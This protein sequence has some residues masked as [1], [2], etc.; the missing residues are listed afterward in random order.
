[1]RPTLSPTARATVALTMKPSKAPTRS[2]T[3]LPSTRPTDVPSGLPST[4]PSE[5]PTTPPSKD[6][7]R[8]PSLS[9]SRLP[10]SVPTGLP[11][12]TPT[13]RPSFEQYVPEEEATPNSSEGV[14]TFAAFGVAGACVGGAGCCGAFFWCSKEKKKASPDGNNAGDSSASAFGTTAPKT[15][16]RPT[17]AI[18]VGS[19]D[20]AIA[21]DSLDDLRKAYFENG[22]VEDEDDFEDISVDNVIS[23]GVDFTHKRGV[24]VVTRSPPGWFFERILRFL[25][26]KKAPVVPASSLDGEESIIVVGS[27]PGWIW[28]RILYFILFCHT[29]A[30]DV[31]SGDESDDI[32]PES[33]PSSVKKAQDDRDYESDNTY[34]GPEHY[35]I[36]PEETATAPA[37]L[38]TADNDKL[39]V[40]V[41]LDEDVEHGY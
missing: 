10:S 39:P 11:S 8:S 7:S 41:V 14:W 3:D 1:V 32:T 30:L 17:R 35:D 36:A 9:P 19:N 24:V 15:T 23:A 22:D 38:K 25:C 13:P 28:G 16:Q 5:L 33:T 20:S 4:T 27:P 37:P 40:D 2:P 12:T 34:D 18:S 31:K 6:P 21:L 26:R 29:K